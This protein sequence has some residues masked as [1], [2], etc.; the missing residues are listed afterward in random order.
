MQAGNFRTL[1]CN[2]T[3]PSIL[4]ERRDRPSDEKHPEWK[5]RTMKSVRSAFMTSGIALGLVFAFAWGESPSVPPVAPTV[6]LTSNSPAISLDVADKPL[7]E[8]LKDLGE[9]SKAT[10]AVEPG[11]THPVTAKIDG[12]TLEQALS[13]LTKD[14][15]ALWARVEVVQN[16]N[17]ALPDEPLFQM[18]RALNALSVKSMEFRLGDGKGT[19]T[20]RREEGA[21]SKNLSASSEALSAGEKSALLYV[22]A[23]KSAD[24]TEEL[25]G[26]NPGD[27]AIAMQQRRFELMQ[28]MSP[29]ERRRALQG[30]Y[31]FMLSLPVEAR[32]QMALD[33]NA[34][35]QSLPPDVQKQFMESKQQTGER[36]KG[37]FSG[38]KGGNPPV[39]KGAY[40]PPNKG[41]IGR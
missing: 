28:S 8:A 29:E 25:A 21:S 23:R 31:Y 15:D 7:S 19:V 24:G 12:A 22:V 9:R 1:G 32:M 37:E 14:H 3:T 39:D 18:V 35:F 5:G 34:A 6:R 38:G 4:N 30:E 36:L 10:I 33:Q 2:E 13:T 27:Q 41:E 17:D 20:L 26:E 16:R 40:P 11:L